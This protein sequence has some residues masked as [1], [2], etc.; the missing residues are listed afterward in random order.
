MSK[1]NE[2]VLTDSK[3]KNEIVLTDSQF[4]KL[5]EE[6]K[7]K[8]KS[9][10]A[11]K[12]ALRSRDFLLVLYPEDSNHVSLLE[13]I[14]Q[15]EHIWQFAYI[16]H[17][18]DIWHEEDVQEWIEEHKDEPGAGEV[19]QVGAPKKPHWHVLIHR[20]DQS[21]AKAQS[22]FFGV[23]V[24]KCSNA[25]GSLMYFVHKTPA[26]MH[27]AQYDW[28]ELKG[29]KKLLDKVLIQKSHFVQLRFFVALARQGCT[30]SDMVTIVEKTDL[31]VQDKNAYLEFLMG[32]AH[33]LGVMSNQELTRDREKM[34]YAQHAD[35]IREA[36]K[37]LNTWDFE[38][39]DLDSY[40]ETCVQL[41]VSV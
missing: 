40:F 20:K 13:Y 15:Y 39:D 12:S 34:R 1:K 21:T 25:E 3:K 27:K 19:P 36:S 38:I 9:T 26:S 37:R 28:D 14:K 29:S 23:H 7:A 41:G 6:V 5:C 11:E 18:R 33:L 35:Y 16:L 2:I 10:Q 8:C 4:E 32:N 22:K 24:K 17:D 30:L 31:S